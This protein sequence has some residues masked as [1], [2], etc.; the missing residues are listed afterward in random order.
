M[1]KFT[2]V[3]VVV[4]YFTYLSVL[5]LFCSD[6]TNTVSCSE[7]CKS[8]VGPKHVDENF[9]GVFGPHKRQTRACTEDAKKN[10]SQ[11]TR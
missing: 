7:Q 6:M 5:V 9:R 11:P 3:D 1:I 4:R 10:Y 2:Y 8:H